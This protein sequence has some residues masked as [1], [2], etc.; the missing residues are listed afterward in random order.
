MQREVET[1]V[2]DMS[3]PVVMIL[4]KLLGMIQIQGVKLMLL[5]VKN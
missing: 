1:K 5:V 4:V 2:K 3:T